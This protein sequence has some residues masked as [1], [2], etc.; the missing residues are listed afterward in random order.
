MRRHRSPRWASGQK[1]VDK[2]SDTGR[3]DG[4]CHDGGHTPKGVIRPKKERRSTRRGN[5][6][7]TKS[8]EEE[9]GI[10]DANTPA[11]S[12]LSGHSVAAI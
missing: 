1:I 4:K 7:L 2:R 12:W 6:G 3:S 8:R 10:A 5:C 9:D 11:E